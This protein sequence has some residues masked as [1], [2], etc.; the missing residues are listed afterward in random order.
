MHTSFFLKHK[1]RILHRD[2]KAA[3]FVP[4][5]IMDG[6]GN[7][8][9]FPIKHGDFNG[10]ILHKLKFWWENQ[11]YMGGFSIARIPWKSLVNAC[12]DLN[13]A[14]LLSILRILRN[15]T[16]YTTR[17]ELCHSFAKWM[18]SRFFACNP[19]H[20]HFFIHVNVTADVE[21][22]PEDQRWR[23]SGRFGCAAGQLAFR[24]TG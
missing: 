9:V 20:A 21:R 17:S 18:E 19:C 23:A 5:E 7:W 10:K 4:T 11:L 16:G 1:P 2:I 22:L 12:Q 3:A 14:M 15:G 6:P 24:G 8:L 13:F